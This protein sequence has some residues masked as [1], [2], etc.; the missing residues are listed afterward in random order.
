MAPTISK[1]TAQTLKNVIEMV[2][3]IDV[4]YKKCEPNFRKMQANLQ[5][6]I[7][8]KSEDELELFRPQMDKALQ[9]LDSCI[10]SIS[11][12]LGLLRTLRQDEALMETKADQINLLVKGLVDKQQLLAKH[13]AKGRDM[14]LGDSQK[15]LETAKNT[16]ESLE[17]ELSELKDIT[18]RAER[19]VK[20]IEE[21]AKPLDEKT[22]AAQNAGDA[23]A[24]SAAR[25]KYLDLGYGD[26][27]RG[28]L[29]AKLRADKLLARLKDSKQRAEAQWA[30]DSLESLRERCRALSKRGQELALLKI[31][32]KPAAPAPKPAKLGNSQ[33][34]AIAK[35]FPLDPKDAKALAK[36]GKLLNDNPHDK[37]P[38]V[39]IKEFGWKKAEVDAG[40]KKANQLP[41]VKDLYLIDI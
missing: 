41:Y 17:A 27:E 3:K 6:A 2:K 11:G 37:W 32:A 4:A 12:A 14:M 22:L 13:A 23:K 24:M 33:I 1:D 31:A 30:I 39:L 29:A 26:Q 21:Q 16:A 35:G 15:A 34:A 25:V 40:M 5:E 18:Q 19:A 9:E 20:Y 10:H 8:D 36:F 28:A 7:D 38:A